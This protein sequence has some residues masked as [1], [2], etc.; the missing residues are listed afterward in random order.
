MEVISTLL[1]SIEVVQIC[2]VV[3]KRF[4]PSLQ[5]YLIVVAL[6]VKE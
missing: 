5:I 1:G 3:E 4:M 6:L 2:N